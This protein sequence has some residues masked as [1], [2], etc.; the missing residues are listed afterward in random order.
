MP[1]PS[2]NALAAQERV[3]AQLKDE[4]QILKKRLEDESV[5]NQ[6]PA[7]EVSV[8]EL[9]RKVRELKDKNHKLILDKQELQKVNSR[10]SGW[11]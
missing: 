2:E 7:R 6:R 9:E 3:I 4:V 1:P 5:A 11:S 10:A 8:E